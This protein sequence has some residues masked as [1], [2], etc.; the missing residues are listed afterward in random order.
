[1]YLKYHDAHDRAQFG[2][3]VRAAYRDRDG[4]PPFFETWDRI[5]NISQVM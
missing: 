4:K 1:M 2:E 5:A 3:A